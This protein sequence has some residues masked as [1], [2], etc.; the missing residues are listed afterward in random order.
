MS[1]AGLWT[2]DP[3][4]ACR[5][6]GGRVAIALR[7]A[8][9]ALL[10]GLRLWAA[11]CLALYV[12]FWLQLD[13]A[14]WAGTSAAVV[15]QP[16]LGAS[17]RKAWF[18]MIGTVIGAVAIVM[19]TARFP[20]DRTG[21]LLGLALW[22]GT[23]ALVA[24]LLRN[25][26]GYAAALAGLTAAVIASDELGAVGGANNDVF[27]FAVVRTSEICIGIICAG[28]VLAST[29]FGGARHRLA[30]QF[31]TIS[32]EI[33]A[34]LTGTSLLV[35]P[36][37]SK[38]RPVRR[39]LIR[40]V[41][42]LDAAIDEALG[43]SSDL[44]PR[45]PALA[46]AA[47][48]LF[49]A[50]SG[51]RT[52]AVHLE[53]MQSDHGRTEAGIVLQ[54]IPPELRS[55]PAQEQA[56]DWTIDPSSGRKACAAAVRSLTGLAADTPS[57]RLL[58]ASAADALIGIRCAL[59]GLLLLLGEPA[60]NI[61]GPRSA[62]FGV[63][64]LLP[65]LV[66]GVRALVTIGAVELFWVVTAWPN[67]AQAIVFAAIAVIVFAPKA[68]QAYTITVSFMLGASIAA[69]LA[70][71]V[72][73]AVLPGLA[74]FGA[75]AL[76]IGL[77]LVPTGTLM[78][79]WP[80]PMFTA[81]IVTFVPLLAPANQMNYDTLQFYNGALAIVTGVGAAALAFCLL[82]PLAPPLRTRG[83]LALTLR[84]LRRLTTK[85]IPRT[86]NQWEARIFSRLSALPEQAEPLQRAQ[87]LAALSV[88]T[89]IIRLRR[90]ARRF[91][92]HAELDAAL[93]ALARGNSSEESSWLPQHQAR[94][95]GQAPGAQQHSCDVGDARPAWCL[96]RFESRTMRFI[97]VDL[98]GV[99]VA[100][101]SVMMAAA[102]LV[103]ITLR[104][105]ADH[106][107]LLRHVWHP[108]LF[109]FA[110]YI[111]VLSSIVLIVAR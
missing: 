51:W 77:V 25:F 73:F 39:D 97:E 67:G 17:L 41:I 83:L 14:Y 38:T 61:P 71:I 54:K 110:F 35:G 85:P 24:T 69:A 102:W 59:D 2:T 56:A 4:Q 72:K 23:S 109:V 20:Q 19:L 27:M 5:P 50:L 111:I 101:I 29:D 104:R 52:A 3:A 36:E 74:T 90:V 57:L 87:L 93:A 7:S 49:A 33:V 53:L 45:S 18:R 28:V 44:R 79:Q 76:A 37:Q 89:E 11:V 105:A 75:F 103:L 12:A 92:L 30:A 47:G 91:E 63:P 48:G 66:N 60:R 64:D 70:A 100:P 43:E 107:G 108:A 13:N 42:A 26:A 94:S 98:F 46:A 1:W 22:G 84:D 9:P 81:M 99:Y 82:P 68:G 78:V 96:F 34:G 95:A 32:A 31:A 15:C 106:F 88:G 58:A 55:V 6:A 21:F 8:A 86:A 10:F 16:S 62:W 40:R 65:A 80:A